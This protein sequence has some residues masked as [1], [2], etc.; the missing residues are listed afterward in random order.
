MVPNRSPSLDKVFVFANRPLS[1]WKGGVP[2]PGG[3]AVKGFGR[4]RGI[5]VLCEAAGHSN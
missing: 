1:F 2:V 3:S 4:E 5:T